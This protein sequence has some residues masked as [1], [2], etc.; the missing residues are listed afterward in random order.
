MNEVFSEAE[1]EKAKELKR[2]HWKKKLTPENLKL[3]EELF[4]RI[5]NYLWSRECPE[6]CIATSSEQ[7]FLVIE[8]KEA[9]GENLWLPTFDELLKLSRL[10]SV[11][12]A[13]T[14][15]FMHRRRFADGREREGLLQLLIEKLR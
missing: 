5:G 10:F 4:P 8:K 13:Q 3:V 15:D 1:V 7:I 9:Q 12:F 14:T 6:G 2:L 11:S